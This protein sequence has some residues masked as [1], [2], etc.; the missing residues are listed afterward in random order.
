[1]TPVEIIN[2]VA[3]LW[4][5]ALVIL[6][7]ICIFKFNKPI[8]NFLSRIVKL[9]AKKGDSGLELECKE[10]K[11][12]ESIEMEKTGA[13]NQLIEVS[14][15]NAEIESSDNKEENS[16]EG[17]YDYL[18]EFFSAYKD[19]RIDKLNEI[20][21][22]LKKDEKLEKTERI[23]NKALFFALSFRLGENDSIEKLVNMAKEQKGEDL[24]LYSYI[25]SMLGKC[26]EEVNQFGEASKVYIAASSEDIDEIERAQFIC[27][28]ANALY[29]LDKKS[30][31]YS[32]L[33][34]EIKKNRNAEALYKAYKELASLYK[35]DNNLFMY[36]LSMEKALESKPNIKNDYFNIAY[37]YS[38]IN[39]NQLALLYYKNVLK[40]DPNDDG[41]LNN[42]GV[43]YKELSL[44]SKS[45]EY[46][47][48]AYEKGSTLAAANV[49]YKYLENGFTAD[50]EKIL[51]EAMGMKSVHAN[52][53]KAISRMHEIIEEEKKKEN[54]IIKE[55]EKHQR[56]LRNY[57]ECY[58]NKKYETKY[59]GIWE[60]ED[61]AQLIIKS[62]DSKVEGNWKDKKIEGEIFNDSIKIIIYDKVNHYG[63][64][65]CEWKEDGIAYICML[66]NGERINLLHIKDNSLNLHKFDRVG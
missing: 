61:K 59:D 37:S 52:V 4:K 7:F 41:A 10:D 45:I 11:Q 42:S 28:S 8:S 17:K 13:S 2:A 19:R 39:Y 34:D 64:S 22:K 57:G 46:Y 62:E 50:A 54:D 18:N 14:A 43:V 27:K 15:I 21:E 60:A 9:N 36:T 25:M 26:Y 20:Y 53:S 65:E 31:A 51:S 49:S 55:A 6:L 12:I 44:N 66:E 48:K 63:K 32:T 47:K 38:D 33:F 35:A 30:E 16:K 40:I 23:K 1:M 56:F 5:L 3:G 24:E 58:F 29:K